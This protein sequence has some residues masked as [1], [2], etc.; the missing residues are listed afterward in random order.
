MVYDNRSGSTYLSALLD[1]V[2]DIGVTLESRLVFEVIKGRKLYGKRSHIENMI[3]R[4]CTDPKFLEWAIDMEELLQRLCSKLPIKNDEFF[5]NIIEM[6]FKIQKPQSKYW[7]YK[8]C[9]PYFAKAV[10]D[11][12][13]YSKFLFIYRDGRAVFSSKKRSRG[14]AMERDPIQA[15]KIWSRTINVMDSLEFQDDIIMIKYEDLIEDTE[16]EIQRI[17]AQIANTHPSAKTNVIINSKRYNSRIPGSQAHLHQ[18]V[19]RPPLK[20]RI[21]GWKNELSYAERYLYEK[22]ACET[23]KQKGYSDIIWRLPKSK[24]EKKQI[25]LMYLNIMY[26]KFA[27]W[28]K[29]TRYYGKRPLELLYILKTRFFSPKITERY[30]H[31]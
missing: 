11:I 29:R 7:I 12:F 27:K 8:G 21:N 28:A 2:D 23:L 10:K 13:P 4:I 15:A 16:N 30:F 1:G 9:D 24:N 26:Y 20:S 31:I 6:Y 17:Y 3:N 22:E 18:N 25:M 14:K 5:Y 19:S